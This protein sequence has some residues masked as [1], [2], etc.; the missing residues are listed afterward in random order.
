MTGGQYR[1]RHSLLPIISMFRALTARN[2]QSDDKSGVYSNMMFNPQSASAKAPIKLCSDCRDEDI[3]THHLCYWH[4]EHQIAGLDICPRHGSALMTFSSDAPRRWPSPTNAL[5]ASPDPLLIAAN[6]HPI[7]RRY[8]RAA[9]KLLGTPPI[10]AIHEIESRLTTLAYQKGLRN[11]SYGQISG[12]SQY[13]GSRLPTAWS[14]AHL[15]YRRPEDPQVYRQWLHPVVE[16]QYYPKALK[17]LPYVA[18]IRGH[19]LLLV[20]AALCDTVEEVI[21]TLTEKVEQAPRCELGAIGPHFTSSV[22]A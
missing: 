13:V 11:D 21:T 19:L 16:N 15:D 4:R 3:G 5:G 6:Q 1:Q 17:Y 14:L 12:L 22:A 10:R 20:L 8:Q 2:A 9:L 18:T 7:V